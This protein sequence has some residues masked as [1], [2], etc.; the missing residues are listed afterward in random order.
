MSCAPPKVPTCYPSCT[1]AGLVANCASQHLHWV[2]A[3]P[4]NITHLY[5]EFNYISEINSSALRGYDQLQQID[6][7]KQNV[8]LTIRNNFFFRQRKLT[9]LE[10][11]EDAAASRLQT[12]GLTNLRQLEI[13]TTSSVLGCP[14]DPGQVMGERRTITKL[15]SMLEN[16]SH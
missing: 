4:P 12:G 5:L 11:M 16:D 6:L 10:I 2:P 1:L 8:Q 14:L 3:L 9:K 15:S 13:Q 7:G